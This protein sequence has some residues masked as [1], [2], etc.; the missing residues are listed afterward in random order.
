[1]KCHSWNR[2]LDL[3]LY[4]YSVFEEF[5]RSG[6]VSLSASFDVADR[7]AIQIVE[8][9]LDEHSNSEWPQAVAS[10][11]ASHLSQSHHVLVR[12]W[13]SE[14]DSDDDEDY[15]LIKVECQKTNVG[16][17]ISPMMRERAE[18]FEGLDE[19]LAALAPFVEEWGFRCEAEYILD[20][21]EWSPCVA[22]P[23]VTIQGS[24]VPFGQITGVFLSP[25]NAHDYNHAQLK[26][27]DDTRFSLEISFDGEWDRDLPEGLLGPVAE[28]SK[29]IRDQLV[30]LT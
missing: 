13:F 27:L 29:D 19:L 1:M 17:R 12:A 24:E 3:L 9:Y 26:L 15:V 20:R 4:W 8:E 30:S 21:S 7:D 10:I 6:L 11:S 18:R 25:A 5:D 16:R 14:F 28:W 23:L 22:L 2:G